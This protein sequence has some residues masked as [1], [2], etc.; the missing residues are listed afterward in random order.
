MLYVCISIG[1]TITIYNMYISV[2]LSYYILF[3][4][5]K[6]MYLS[7]CLCCYLSIY[8]FIYL[9]GFFKSQNLT[10]GI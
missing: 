1:F 3:I 5:H 7:L 2:N 10:Y 6:N 9:V 4:L 8:L